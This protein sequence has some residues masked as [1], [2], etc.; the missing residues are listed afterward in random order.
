[1]DVLPQKG[2]ADRGLYCLAYCISLAY[3][4]DPCSCV[5]SQDETRLHL[6]ASLEKEHLTEIPVV[7]KRS[8]L[9][10]NFRSFMT[11]FVCS[12]C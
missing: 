2:A 3:K 7:K 12:V 6:K 10:N 4:E 5:Y 8:Q 1:M 11:L 9:T